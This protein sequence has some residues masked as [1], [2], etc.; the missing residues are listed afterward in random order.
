MTSPNAPLKLLLNT[1]GTTCHRFRENG[2][3]FLGVEII[4]MNE[5]WL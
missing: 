3:S 5:V 1:D 4:S 2:E